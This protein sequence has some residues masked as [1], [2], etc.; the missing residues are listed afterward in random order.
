MGGGIKEYAIFTEDAYLDLF[1]EVCSL[2]E[3]LDC[4]EQMS[5]ELTWSL[6]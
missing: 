5:Q 4:L 2:I 6:K 3:I 1:P